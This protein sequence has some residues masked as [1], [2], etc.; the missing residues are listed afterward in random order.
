[1]YKIYFKNRPI[2]YLFDDM[3]STLNPSSGM[4]IQ[5]KVKKVQILSCIIDIR[6]EAIK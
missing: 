1:M 5:I 2:L 6:D 4:N 3:I